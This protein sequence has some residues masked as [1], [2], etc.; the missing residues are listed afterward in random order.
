MLTKTGHNYYLIDSNKRI[1]LVNITSLRIVNVGNVPF[2]VCGQIIMPGNAYVFPS[3]GTVSDFEQEV[4]FSTASGA[5]A[6]V[7]YKQEI[8]QPTQCS[9]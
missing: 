2:E 3:D 7:E 4:I 9:N 6:I 8:Q 1:H 5:S